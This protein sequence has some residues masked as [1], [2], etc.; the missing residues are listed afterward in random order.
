MPTITHM[1]YVLAVPDLARASA[2]F[3]D[4]LGFTRQAEP[5]GWDFVVRDGC[6]VMLGECPDDMA[7]AELGSHSYFGYIVVD[8]L[9]AFHAEIAAKGAI[10]RKPPADQPWGMREMAVGTPDGHRIMFAQPL[11]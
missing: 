8:D 6:R 4:V 2:Y 1:S 11:A 5:P 7:P 9:D 3:R 10:I